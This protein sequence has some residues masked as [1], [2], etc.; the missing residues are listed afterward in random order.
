MSETDDGRA[1]GRPARRLRAGGAGSSAGGS[2]SSSGRGGGA[3][4]TERR[5]GAA[6]GGTAGQGAGSGRP[7]RPG[8]AGQGQPGRS[9]RKDDDA[10]AGRP[11]RGGAAPGR[12]GRQ[13]R[14]QAGRPAE[15]E[16]PETVTGRELDREVR[17]DLAALSAEAA[18]QVARHLVMAGRLLDSD[19][20]AS[21][22]HALAAQRRA[23]RVAVVREAAG[24]A[25]YRAGDYEV[26]LREL[27]TAQRLNGIQDYL[28]MMA[29]CERGLGRPEKALA[30]AGGP[31]ARH[32]D[33]AGRI[34]LALVVAGARLDLGQPAAAVV[35]LQLPELSRPVTAVTAVQVARLMSAYADALSA[36]G[37]VTEALE[38]AERAVAT[39]PDVRAE[40]LAGPDEDVVII[41]VTDELDA[42]A[43]EVAADPA[44]ERGGPADASPRR[45][46]ADD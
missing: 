28:P 1:G 19:P 22:A 5:Q 29:D 36:A 38:W 34:E 33:R 17:R 26:A 16:L 44:S 27:R 14:A 24:V 23:G 42:G 46:L 45:R 25:A 35:A 21:L 39:D 9:K 43:E 20:R 41:D 2:G 6:G 3:G 31:S 4:Q 11:A 10:G 30:L 8:R 7:A 32:L 12:S 18:T 40:A 15:P 37:R 13:P